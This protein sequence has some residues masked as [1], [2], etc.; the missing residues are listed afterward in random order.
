MAKYTAIALTDLITD[1]DWKSGVK[2]KFRVSKYNVTH[3]Y[4]F[5]WS[6][7]DPSVQ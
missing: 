2:V 4:W 1:S 6:Q 5:Q 7:Q 3:N